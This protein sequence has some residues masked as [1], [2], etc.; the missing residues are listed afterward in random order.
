MPAPRRRPAPRRASRASRAAVPPAPRPRRREPESV[1]RGRA[2]EFAAALPEL[3]G[4][5]PV[6][7]LVL[8]FLGGDG[9]PDRRM[10]LTLRLDLPPA[11]H[12]REV[13]HQVVARAA[14]LRP[15]GALLFVVTEDPDVQVDVVAPDPW[16]DTPPR[17]DSAERPTVPDL[18]RRPLVHAVIEE[19]SAHGTQTVDAVLVRDGRWWSYPDVAPATGAGAGTALD[20]A[21]SRLTG[22]AA[23]LGEVVDPDR[24]AVVARA[25]PT[26][27]TSAE[28]TLLC[29][30][31]D[32][33]LDVR[34]ARGATL[35]ELTDEGWAVVSEAVGAHIPGARTPMTDADLARVG[36]A[37]TLVTVRDRALSLCAGDDDDLLAA[38]EALWTE[39]NDRLPEELAPVPAM[40]LGL[41][42][43]LRGAGVLAVAALER[44]RHC[45]H[46]AMAELLLQAVAANTEPAVLRALLADPE[47]PPVVQVSGGSRPS[48]PRPGT[49]AGWPG[50]P[51]P[52]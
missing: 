25:W 33:Q 8:L 22:I 48:P 40:L 21:A 47:D 32:A 43:W 14:A 31:A 15:A 11:E 38:A 23:L 20:P 35:D 4:F 24:D 1:L 12:D 29:R 17:V 37:L 52:R 2:E 49:P 34:I 45:G 18:P 26:R 39:L 27:P 46:D 30:R 41:S 6:E 51:R 42:A 7:S 50:W 44:S 9:R 36:V 28:L 3:L 19:L 10:S 13:A 5:P 16:R